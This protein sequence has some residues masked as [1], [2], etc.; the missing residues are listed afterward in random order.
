MIDVEGLG[1]VGA[2]FTSRGP[3]ELALAESEGASELFICQPCATGPKLRSRPRP[4]SFNIIAESAGGIIPVSS[5]YPTPGSYE[6]H[7]LTEMAS[8][9]CLEASRLASR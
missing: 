9:K 2:S 1:T 6:D 7:Y 3:L 5:R 4:I 8:N